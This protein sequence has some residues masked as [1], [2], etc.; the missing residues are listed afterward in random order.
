MGQI[1]AQ[2]SCITEH[3]GFEPVCLNVWVLQAG[4]F[5]YRQHYGMHDIQDQPGY[6]QVQGFLLNSLTVSHYIQAIQIYL[7]STVYY[8][9]GVGIGLEE[10]KHVLPSCVDNKIWTKFPSAHNVWFKYH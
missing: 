4:Y 9:V 7:L 6:E 5:S 10:K 8:I 3:Q 2:I 1:Q